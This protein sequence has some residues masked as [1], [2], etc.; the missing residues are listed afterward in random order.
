MPHELCHTN[1]SRPDRTCA[2]TRPRDRGRRR[3]NR[4]HAAHSRTVAVTTPCRA[5]VPHVAAAFRRW[6]RVGT[7]GLSARDRG[8]QPPRRLGRLEHLRRQ[9]FGAGRAV[10]AARDDAHDLRRSACCRL[11][12]ATQRVEGDRRA[13]RLPR[14]RS[15]ELRFRLPSGHM[16]GRALPRGGARRFAAPE[17]R[18]QAD[19]S[20]AAMSGRAGNAAR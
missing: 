18:G 19:G 20:D 9:Q 1:H 12:G 16:D 17:R 3:C 5:A 6:R 8:D 2:R 10:P 4:T 13:G 11:L 15:M 7:M 14:H